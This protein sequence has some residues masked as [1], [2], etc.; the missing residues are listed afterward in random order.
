MIVPEVR[1]MLELYQ[2]DKLRN[3]CVNGALHRLVLLA[4]I[5]RKRHEVLD[6]GWGVG[7]HPQCPRSQPLFGS[8]EK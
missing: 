4:R 2:V 7:Q 3:V 5:L 1:E 6:I 8:F